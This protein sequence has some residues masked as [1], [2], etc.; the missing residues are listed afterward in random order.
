MLGDFVRL[1]VGR[2]LGEIFKFCGA[3]RGGRR[4][5]ASM[6]TGIIA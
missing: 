3:G 6:M 5:S 4:I 1:G 2:D